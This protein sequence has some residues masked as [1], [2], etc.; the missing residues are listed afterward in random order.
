MPK[1]TKAERQ[2]RYAENLR[3][4]NQVFTYGGWRFNIDKAQ[5]IIAAKPREIVQEDVARWAEAYDIA[6]LR[7][8]AEPSHRII[9]APDPRYFNREHAQT[10]DPRVP[11]IIALMEDED[12]KPFALLIDGIHRLYRHLVEENAAMPAVYLTVDETTAIRF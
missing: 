6:S 1:S 3:K 5:Q 11:V 9:G 10:L 7:P 4:K 2:A 12:G 8:G